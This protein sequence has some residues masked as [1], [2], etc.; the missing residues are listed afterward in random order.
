MIDYVQVVASISRMLLSCIYFCFCLFVPNKSA[1]VKQSLLV[2]TKD[3]HFQQMKFSTYISYLFFVIINNL[4]C[5]FPF[6]FTLLLT[7]QLNLFL[8]ILQGFGIICFVIC[9]NPLSLQSWSS[10][11]FYGHSLH[12]YICSCWLYLCF[13]LQSVCSNWMGKT[14]Y[15]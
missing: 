11:Y 6:R 13:F 1:F 2:L 7:Y 3:V 4:F 15:Y 8:L 12:S 9:R 5:S 10:L 14:Y